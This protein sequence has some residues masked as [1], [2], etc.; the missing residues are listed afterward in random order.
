M[1]KNKVLRKIFGAKKDE[2]TG[3]WRKLHS[4]ELHVLYS[5][6]NTI[7]KIKSR[8]LR[9]AGLVARMEES[10]NAYCILMGKPEGKSFRETD[11]QMGR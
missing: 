11:T 2:I 6:P 5:S 1:F 8:L 10:R 4:A 3:E 9:W 7:R